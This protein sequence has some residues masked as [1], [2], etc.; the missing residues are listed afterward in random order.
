MTVARDKNL[1]KRRVDDYLW[2]DRSKTV[3]ALRNS[4]QE[5]FFGFRNVYI[6]GGMVR[7][8][9]RGGTSRFKSDVD[10]VIEAPASQ[11]HELAR[12]VGGSSNLSGGFGVITERWHIDFWALET[13][14]A[15]REGHISGNSIDDLLSGT[16][17]DWDAVYYDLRLRR[18][19][20]KPDYLDRLRS[21][22]LGINLR[23]TPS[24]VPN[25][26]RAIRRLV[27]WDLVPSTELMDFIVSVCSEVSLSEL[28]AFELRKYG[29]SVCLKFDSAHSL[30]DSLSNVN[31]GRLLVVESPRQ[32][33][34]P[35]FY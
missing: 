1:L 34:L 25:A 28:V 32:M 17:F 12:R 7:D 11:V 26:I 16:F 15:Y 3:A 31:R 23:A 20:M 5:N 22:V 9:A 33:R 14:W 30:L 29:N 13:T 18:V 27:S 4:L 2:R 21:R 6:F 8:F 24:T 19:G 10:L 35:G